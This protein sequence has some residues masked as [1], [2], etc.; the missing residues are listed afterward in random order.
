[1]GDTVRIKGF[2]GMG[3]EAWGIGLSLMGIPW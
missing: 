1:M 2:L 3:E